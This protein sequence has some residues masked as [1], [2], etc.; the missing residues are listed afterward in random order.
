MYS[1]LSARIAGDD[2]FRLKFFAPQSSGQSSEMPAA[3][4]EHR[5]ELHGISVVPES[6][7]P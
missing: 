6:P 1:L 2:D 4:P 3:P 5:E 7:A